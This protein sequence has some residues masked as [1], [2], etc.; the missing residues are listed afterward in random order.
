MYKPGDLISVRHKSLASSGTCLVL[1]VKK[2]YNFYEVVVLH[3]GRTFTII[4]DGA[5]YNIKIIRRGTHEEES[6]RKTVPEISKNI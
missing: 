3:E 6:T 2:R 4:D 5:F 1:S